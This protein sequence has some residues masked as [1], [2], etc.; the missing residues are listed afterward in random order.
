LMSFTMFLFKL[1]ENK[2]SIYK[3]NFIDFIVALLP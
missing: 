2:L 3:S 1:I